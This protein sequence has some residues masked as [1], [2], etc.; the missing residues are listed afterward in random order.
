[1]LHNGMESS[2]VDYYKVADL[3]WQGMTVPDAV[4]ELGYDWPDVDRTMTMKVR[5]YLVDVAILANCKEDYLG[6]S[7]TNH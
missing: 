5:S 1:V 6:D 4:R 3:V 7:K 2:Q